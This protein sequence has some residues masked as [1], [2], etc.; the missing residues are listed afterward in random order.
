V[1]CR[2][3]GYDGFRLGRYHRDAQFYLLGCSFARNMRDTAIYRVPTSNIIQWGHR[4][5]YYNCHREG[6]DDFDW[7]A[8]NL[9]AGLKASEINIKWVFNGRWNPQLN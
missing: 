9:P 8:D 4:V 6:G 3:K 5:Y 2:F 1:N 7:Y